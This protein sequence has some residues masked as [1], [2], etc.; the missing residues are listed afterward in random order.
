MSSKERGKVQNISRFAYIQKTKCEVYGYPIS[1]ITILLLGA[2]FFMGIWLIIKYGQS[3]VPSLQT[4]M[5]QNQ[6]FLIFSV[7]GIL[8]HQAFVGLGKPDNENLGKVFYLTLFCAIAVAVVQFIIVSLTKIS[9][10]L[11]DQMFFYACAGISEEF[12]FR[13]G[14]QL[15]IERFFM[16]TLS[17]S[18][19]C[20]LLSTILAITITSFMFALYHLFVKESVSL[21]LAVFL[22]SVILGIFL[23]IGKR[24]DVTILAHVIVNLIVVFY[25]Q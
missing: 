3:A 10:S 19:R 21:M 5:W 18:S 25:A 20:N 15:S 24:I 7:S 14:L 22:S 13:F 6:S 9:I 23:R 12:L 8:L 17:N 4:F 11:I 1:N 2:Q 16:K